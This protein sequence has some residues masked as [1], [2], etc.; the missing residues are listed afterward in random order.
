MINK[1]QIHSNLTKLDSL[2]KKSKGQKDAA[3]YSKLAILELCGWIEHSMDDIVRYCANCNLRE[4]QNIG[5]ME[6][7]I[8]RTSS[9]SYSSSPLDR[10]FRNMLMN[11]IGMINLEGL[12]L[13][14]NKG[15]FQRM[16]S[17]LS[18]LKQRRDNL[19]HTY[20]RGRTMNI[21]SPSVTYNR[22]VQV[23]NGLKE[24]ERNVRKV[25]FAR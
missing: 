15:N 18:D 11:L 24:I 23:Y 20:L 19:A 1:A 3:F 2:Y 8:K 7:I 14:V 12:E 5:F 10:N 9:F 13:S 16:V 21:D 4:A 22:F 25:R 6:E 17:S